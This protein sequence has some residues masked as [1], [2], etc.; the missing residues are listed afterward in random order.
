MIPPGCIQRGG[1]VAIV[2][3]QIKTIVVVIITMMIIII[4]VISITMIII[5]I[6]INI[7]MIMIII[8][9]MMIMIIVTVIINSYCLTCCWIVQIVIPRRNSFLRAMP[10]VNLFFNNERHFSQK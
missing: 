6:I 10:E 4:I 2:D 1:K 8:I 5:I 7:I 9:I 3:I